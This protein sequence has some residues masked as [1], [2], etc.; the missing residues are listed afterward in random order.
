MLIKKTKT[1]TTNKNTNNTRFNKKIHKLTDSQI[2]KI[3]RT[4]TKTRT[5]TTQAS[6]RNAQI[7]IFTKFQQ[8][9]HKF[10]KL[11][12]I[13]PFINSDLGLNHFTPFIN[14]STNPE[15][16]SQLHPQT[17]FVRRFC[18]PHKFGSGFGKCSMMFLKRPW[19]HEI[20]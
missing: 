19:S 4:T 14:P 15:I 16:H 11:Q 20:R 3:S 17:F 5:L 7:Q 12:P 9:I 18:T 6:T 10:G 8:E 1:T 2:H 13:F